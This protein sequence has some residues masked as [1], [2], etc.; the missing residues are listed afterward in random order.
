MYTLRWLILA[1]DK[2]HQATGDA[3]SILFL[4]KMLNNTSVVEQLEIN[5]DG[6]T[7][8][9]AALALIVSKA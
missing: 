6:V 1:T 3:R 9:P 5:C 4:W 7:V 2:V 8:T